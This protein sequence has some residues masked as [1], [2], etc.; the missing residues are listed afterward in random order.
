MLTEKKE[1]DE[2]FYKDTMNK[3]RKGFNEG[4]EQGKLEQAEDYS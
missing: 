2:Y 4:I 3:E 1:I